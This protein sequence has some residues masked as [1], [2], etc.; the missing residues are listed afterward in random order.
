MGGGPHGCP[1]PAFP[2]GDGSVLCSTSPRV[3]SNSPLAFIFPEVFNASPN[4]DIDI[5]KLVE[6]DSIRSSPSAGALGD[7]SNEL[8]K[9]TFLM[10]FDSAPSPALTTTMT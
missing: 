7:I 8:G 1:R 6:Q 5:P 10:S 3:R 4:I 9:G 2:H